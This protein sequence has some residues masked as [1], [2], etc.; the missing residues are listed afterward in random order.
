MQKNIGGTER[1]IRVLV[2]LAITSLAFV[3]PASP[4]AFLGLVPVATGLIGWCPPYAMFGIN[5]CKKKA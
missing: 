5:T 4:W 2:G 3:G 1:V